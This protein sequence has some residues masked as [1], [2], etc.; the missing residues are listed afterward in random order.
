M[1]QFSNLY[2][3]ADLDA[4][5]LNLGR[6]V[7]SVYQRGKVCENL[8]LLNLSQKFS[9]RYHTLLANLSYAS[10]GQTLGELDILVL[11]SRSDKVIAVY[12]VKC[13]ESKKARTASKNKAKRQLRRFKQYVVEQ[14]KLSQA[15]HQAC[16]I[17]LHTS[18]SQIKKISCNKFIKTRYVYIHPR[19][20]L[21]SAGG[22]IEDED[23]GFT[24]SQVKSLQRRLNGEAEDD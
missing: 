4:A 6:E 19:E 24:M 2:A 20:H 1:V 17:V 10:N 15:E 12:E 23:F 9:K 11:N 14:R 3:T 16:M 7:Q 13:S 21:K 5:F 8:A 22:A 18:Q